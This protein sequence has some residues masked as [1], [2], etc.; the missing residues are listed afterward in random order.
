MPIKSV[1]REMRF[2]RYYSLAITLIAGTF[3][4]AAAH[5]AS[6]NA[7]IDT[8]TVHR[9]NV[10]DREG[11]LAVVVTSHDDF[12]PPIVNGKASSARAATTTGCCS[13]TSAVTSRAA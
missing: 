10:V 5:E 13:T 6:S 3:L 4:L 12:P 1:R 7:T 11:K 2:L 8:L 9:I